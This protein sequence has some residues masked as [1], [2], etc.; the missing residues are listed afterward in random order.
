MNL[1]PNKLQRGARLRTQSGRIVT[2]IKTSKRSLESNEELYRLQHPSGIVGNQH[3]TRDA[4]QEAGV[5]EI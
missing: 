3:W 4:L 2:M 5:V 1:L